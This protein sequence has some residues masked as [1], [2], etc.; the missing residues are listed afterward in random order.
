M[1]DSVLHSS[2]VLVDGKP[3]LRGLRVERSMVVVRVRVAIKVPGRID[4]GVH[5]IGFAACRTAALGTS[6][7]DELRDLAE[8]RSAGECDIDI[9]W[10]NHGQSFFG[11]GNDAIF[12]AI[13]HWNGRSPISLARDSPIFQ[14]IGNGGFAETFFL[15]DGRH[16]LD[17]LGA[18]E[19]AVGTG[20]DQHAVVSHVWKGRLGHGFFRVVGNWKNHQANFEF[21]LFCKLVVTLVVRG[22]AHDGA[23]AVIH[24][25]VVRHPEGNFF[26]VERIDGVTSSEDAVL[27]DF[28]DVAYFFG[29]ALL[30]DQLIDLGA[31][32][33]VGGGEIGNERMLRRELHR[34]RAEDGIDARGEDADGGTG[35]AKTAVV[36]C[37][38]ELEIDERALAAADPVPL[39]GSDFF[40]P[41]AEL[42]EVTQ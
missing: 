17:G 16:F 35:R 14:A 13:E 19:A 33:G 26:V 36:L 27:L 37:V 4:E 10:Q 32:A 25:D 34:C 30:G 2:D 7:V 3:V 24:E 6:R 42:I 12:V 31:Q 1:Q 15:R 41:P 22:N 20:I 21:V 9:L 5:G 40:G 39:H 11:H 38:V 28:A 23:R 18:L 8:R 29:F